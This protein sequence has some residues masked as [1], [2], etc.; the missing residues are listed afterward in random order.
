[1]SAR[2]AGSSGSRCASTPSSTRCCSPPDILKHRLP[3]IDDELRRL[4]QRQIESLERRHGDDFPAQ[5]RSVLHT[6][7]MTGHAKADQVA[8]LFGMH[9][10]TLNR[11]LNAFGVAFQQ[12]VDESRF[13]IARQM[14]EYSAIEVGQIS[15]SAR[16]RRARRVHAGV[17]PLERHDAGRV[18]S[19]AQ[20]RAPRPAWR[21]AMP[22]SRDGAAAATSWPPQ[23]SGAG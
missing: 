16:L 22:E 13:E 14:L 11:R 4:L 19:D 15:D 3:G 8:A 20:S 17:S 2:S 6:A 18:A 12:L 23:R 10:R 5:V 9:S 7:L 21:T 1:M